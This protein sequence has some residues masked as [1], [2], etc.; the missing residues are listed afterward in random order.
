MELS[1]LAAT[2]TLRRRRSSS[3]AARKLLPVSIRIWTATSAALP[4]PL[5]T[6]KSASNSA[7]KAPATA[8]T[9]AGRLIP[10]TGTVT[11][12]TTASGIYR[13]QLVVDFQA[14][15]ST[16]VDSIHGGFVFDGSGTLYVR[17]L[18]DASGNPVSDVFRLAD[19]KTVDVNL[20]LSGMGGFGGADPTNWNGI[21]MRVANNGG[22]DNIVFT[23]GLPTT[24]STWAADAGDWLSSGNWYIGVPNAIGAQANFTAGARNNS[25]VYA[26]S[27]IT[28]GTINFDSAKTYNISG[29][30]SLTLQV[31]TGNAAINVVTGSQKINL[32]LTIASNTVL[33]V[34][35]GTT[36]RISDPVTVAAG[37]SLSK[38]GLG[39]VLYESTI[40]V[41]SGGSNAFADS[42]HAAS[43]QLQSTANASIAASAAGSTVVQFDSVSF[44]SGAKIDV[45]NNKL[46]LPGTPAAIL[47]NIQSGSIYS[48]ATTA[49][50]SLGY[51]D[52]G[53]GNTAVLFTL[54][55]DATL[56]RSVGF[57]DLLALAKSY[58]ATNT[59]WAQGDFNY[60][61]A[62]TFD[63]L[64][65]LAKN[66][67][68]T[69]T[70]AAGVGSADFQAD[71]ALAQS[72]APEPTSLL[73][74][75]LAIT[76]CSARRRRH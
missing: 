68:G 50:K 2:P 16:V 7:T 35:T 19:S 54:K 28:A 51:G 47:A 13:M 72:L 56:D 65:A 17:Q 43:L 15:V 41:Q 48:S 5:K 25:T 74:A 60:D 37:K 14:N 30:G 20:G 29:A 45:A 22:L 76:G 26:D 39:T 75:G 32:P 69:F 73:V 58:N 21:D 67:N 31:A 36:L 40:N 64:L 1:G 4:P 66:Y 12:T 46:I 44:G 61:G 52:I 9:S 34:A 23:N 33:N 49:S 62:T 63:D 27:A 55:G 8:G 53:G 10:N 70:P 6:A 57:D 11:A 42:S 38:T 3:I 59:V 24:V 18:A 71:W